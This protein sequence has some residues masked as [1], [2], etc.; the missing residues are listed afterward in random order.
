MTVVVEPFPGSP[1]ARMVWRIERVFDS[2][3]YP[4]ST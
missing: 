3:R 1:F 4:S 2:I